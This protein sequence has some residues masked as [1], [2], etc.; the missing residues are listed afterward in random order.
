MDGKKKPPK[1]FLYLIH[2]TLNFFYIYMNG[3]QHFFD[4]RSHGYSEE[5]ACRKCPPPPIWGVGQL[6]TKLHTGE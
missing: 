5:W 3:R 4:D 6:W 2:I 1:H